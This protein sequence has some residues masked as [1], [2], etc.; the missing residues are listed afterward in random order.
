MNRFSRYASYVMIL[1]LILCD[2]FSLSAYAATEEEGD[3]AK[4]PTIMEESHTKESE[5]VLDIES[6]PDIVGVET[7]LEKGHIKRQYDLEAEFLNHVVFENVDGSKTLYIYDYPVKYIS[8]SGEI[9]D[10]RLDVTE[11]PANQGAFQSIE[12][13]IKVYFPKNIGEG[14]SLN[15]DA[16]S[17]SLIPLLPIEIQ[18]LIGKPFS[19]KRY[20]ANLYSDTVV[21]SVD[22][23]TSY[24]YTPTYTGYKED[25]VVSEYTGQTEYKFRLLTNGLTLTE[26][27]GAYY[28]TDES[29]KIKA[30]IGD[31][32]VFTADEKNNCLGSLSHNEIVANNE[33]ELIIHLDAE[34][35]RDPRTSYPIR[36]DPI[37]EVNY[38]KSGA[39][40]IEDVTINSA[41]GSSGS[42]GSLFV[43]L[44][45]SGVARI[46][47][48][49]PT[50]N[51][52]TIPSADCITR[53][54]VELRDL[55]CESEPLTVYCH[56]FT[57][58][59]WT[60]STATWANVN[61]NSYGSTLS[62]CMIS[63]SQGQNQTTTHRYSFAITGVVKGW[64]NNNYS[65]GK[66][67]IFKASSDCE[68]GSKYIH[69][70][71]ASYNRTSYRP[72]FSM[73]YNSQIV[74]TF[75]DGMYYING[76][77]SGDYIRY[78]SSSVLPESGLLSSL[79]NTIK[80]QINKV[81]G[82]YVIRSAS[83]KTKYLAVST[84]S[85]NHTVE[86]VTVSNASIPLRCKWD[87]TISSDN[88]CLIKSVF[89][90]K[91]L[92][93]YGTTLYT[94]STLGSPNTS[95]YVSR[96]WRIV[97][98]S[99]YG[100]SSSYSFR[101]LSTSGNYIEDLGINLDESKQFTINLKYSNT[102]WTDASDFTYYLTADTSNYVTIRAL[103]GE[104]AGTN[105]G[106]AE[107]TATHK[108]T[109]QK[110]KFKIYVDRYLFE[111]SKQFGFAD[112]DSLL[113]HSIYSKVDAAYPSYSS[114]KRA[115]V[116]ARALG[117]LVYNGK[118][119]ITQYGGLS[120]FKW[121]D[122]AGK[123]YGSS[124][125]QS[126]FTS[127]LGYTAKEYQNLKSAVSVQHGITAN[128]FAHLQ[129]SL[130][131]RLAY[132]H[133][134]DGFYSNIGTGL[135]DLDISYMA[136]WLGDATIHGDGATH[137]GDDDYCADLDAENIYR[138]IIQGR[139]SVN[140]INNYYSSLSAN[141]TRSQIF[142][143]YIGFETVKKKIFKHLVDS[144][145]DDESYRLDYI[146]KHYPDTY[147]FICSLRDRRAHIGRY[148]HYGN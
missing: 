123:L 14:I 65:Q 79:G 52:A 102:L 50:L 42:S 16:I 114:T 105:I 113:I 64:K 133:D 138:L 146:D 97:S 15:N 80:W 53:A 128:D 58:N 73:T 140:A 107:C 31:V 100:N 134:I 48:R 40:G 111:L 56:P 4:F 101:E 118:D 108:V 136:G 66:G 104:I 8:E 36:I 120:A 34:Y 99:S 126:F 24:E 29:G 76:K 103:T 74:Q 92:Y 137:L 23:K 96:G 139:S 17:V 21:Y 7:A 70:T 132:Y 135:S 9:K 22:D 39:G 83:D 63:Y 77:Y 85:S 54:T 115:W 47:M 81:D 145:A 117:G 35:L 25:I 6:V 125:E 141:I 44:R 90:N 124:S 37:V 2:S 43:G 143:E 55:M 122:V 98:V 127:G 32:I 45:N 142:L 121:N 86:V 147:N 116:C 130:A 112:S 110:F 26:L 30:N 148:N 33:Y 13:S 51:L 106:I 91:Y 72:S 71:F 57:G 94:S 61:P 41:G 28:L 95:Q 18:P 1:L 60:E 84:T 11:N 87:I 19:G 78:T 59:T 20:T 69:K 62:S 12:N 119:S 49:F 46:L 10:V 93:T 38:D 68:A 144:I 27:G 3:V 89:N 5:S 129:I 75:P 88:A 82:K 131:A 67:I 109:N